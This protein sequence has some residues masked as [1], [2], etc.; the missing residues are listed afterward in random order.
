MDGISVCECSVNDI[1]RI[2]TQIPEF[3]N[4]Y[5]EAE[6][7]RRLSG[8][9][10]LAL[11]ASIEGIDVGF[12]LGY[13]ID[14]DTFYTWFGGVL[15]QYRKLGMAQKLAVSQ[16]EWAVAHGYKRI[17]LKTRNYLKPMLIFALKN[18][19]YIHEVEL[20]PAPRDNRI[21]LLKELE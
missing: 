9:P 18:G 6:Y 2:A 8:T 4:P 20:R 21:I 10:F 13:A 12:K 14:S 19:F 11:K 16:E 15:P 7:N 5:Q 17:K 3:D 1:I